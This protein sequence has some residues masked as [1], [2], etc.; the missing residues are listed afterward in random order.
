M[1]IKKILPR[2]K[3]VAICC[4]SFMV[5]SCKQ[6]SPSVADGDEGNGEVNVIGMTD[7]YRSGH[8][9]YTL[10]SHGEAIKFSRKCLADV[11][12]KPEDIDEDYAIWR[13]EFQYEDG[14]YLSQ[15]DAY[16]KC[17]FASASPKAL[18][19]CVLVVGCVYEFDN[20]LDEVTQ[21]AVH[22][23]CIKE[24]E[25][26]K[27]VRIKK[28]NG[29]FTGEYKNQHPEARIGFYFDNPTALCDGMV[30]KKNEKQH[31]DLKWDE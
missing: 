7:A 16:K 5:M 12:V 25:K 11:A 31:A 19:I 4:F 17:V 10:Q 27:S 13:R 2:S 22:E 14:S 30:D 24:G 23:N 28:S 1:S 29:K 8:Y 9:L 20:N 15:L 26:F 6:V 18:F 3:V 21:G